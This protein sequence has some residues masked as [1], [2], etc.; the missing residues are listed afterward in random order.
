VRRIGLRLDTARLL[1]KWQFSAVLW[2]GCAYGLSHWGDAGQTIG[3]RNI[4]YLKVLFA[5]YLYLL[6]QPIS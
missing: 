1:E 3:A 5:P 4:P 2:I 6:G